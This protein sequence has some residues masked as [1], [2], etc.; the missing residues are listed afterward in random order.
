MIIYYYNYMY[1]KTG[2]KRDKKKYNILLSDKSS[3]I[4]N[5]NKNNY[6][7]YIENLKN[8]LISVNFTISFNES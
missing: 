8:Y 4:K 1:I 2:E 5:K 7:Q 3:K 6:I